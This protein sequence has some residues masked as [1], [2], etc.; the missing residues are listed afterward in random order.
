MINLRLFPKFA[1]P[2]LCLTL[3]LLAACGQPAPSNTASPADASL[4]IPTDTPA[5]APTSAPE[6]S[7]PVGT[8]AET[9]APQAEATTATLAPP[10]DLA[11]HH[12]PERAVRRGDR[13]TTEQLTLLR[14]KPGV[15]KLVW[16]TESEEANFGFNIKRATTKDGPF[17]PVNRLVILGAGDSSTANSYEF[18]DLDVKIGD[19]FFYQIESISMQGVL[20]NMGPVLPF[21]VNREFLGYEDEL[22]TGT[23]TADTATTATQP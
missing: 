22:T 23:A 11:K 17:E 1:A 2:A 18:Y 13:L 10:R 8:P 5:P 16:R 3:A 21:T 14:G 20:D 15:V 7:A 12:G 6:A 19:E 9:P 4:P